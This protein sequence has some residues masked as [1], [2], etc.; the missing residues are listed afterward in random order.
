MFVAHLG[1]SQTQSITAKDLSTNEQVNITVE[2]IDQAAA[3]SAGVVIVL[4]DGYI[5]NPVGMIVGKLKG[6]TGGYSS[7]SATTVKG[8]TIDLN[9]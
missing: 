1:F 6:E 8:S 7:S 4:E 9:P 5:I 3:N 2:F